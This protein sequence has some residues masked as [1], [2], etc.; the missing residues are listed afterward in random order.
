[1]V[2]LDPTATLFQAQ[3]DGLA[4]APSKRSSRERRHAT[5][6]LTA[7]TW[8]QRSHLQGRACG[9][10]RVAGP[11]AAAIS[12]GPHL[13]RGAGTRPRSRCYSTLQSRGANTRASVAGQQTPSRRTTTSSPPKR[14]S[15]STRAR[16]LHHPPSVLLS[17]RSGTVSSSRCHAV[18]EFVAQR[19]T[20]A[21]SKSNMIWITQF[22]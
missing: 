4:E 18:S 6:N 11:S 19:W 5:R 7:C 2:D 13:V 1:M 20:K 14:F 16:S 8:R 10:P 9:S 3:C 12:S 21:C 17:Q 15:L 22:V